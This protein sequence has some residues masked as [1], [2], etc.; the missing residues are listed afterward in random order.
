MSTNQNVCKPLHSSTDHSSRIMADASNNESSTWLDRYDSS[1]PFYSRP[2]PIMIPIFLCRNLF[3]LSKY[4]SL[5]G[6][7]SSW[8]TQVLCQTNSQGEISQKLKFREFCFDNYIA[9]FILLLLFRLFLSVFFLYFL[10]LS[11]MVLDCID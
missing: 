2:I 9:S 3:M 8:I 10:F 6:S 1:G 4:L 5:Q 7:L 11:V